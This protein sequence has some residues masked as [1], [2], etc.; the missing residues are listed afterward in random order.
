VDIDKNS[1]EFNTVLQKMKSTMN[2]VNIIKL[3]RIQ[4]KSMWSNF[5]RSREELKE[6]WNSA[7]TELGDSIPKNIIVISNCR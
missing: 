4:K 2:N 6:K 5:C 1:A 3:E 7:P